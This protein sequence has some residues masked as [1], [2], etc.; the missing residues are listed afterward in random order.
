MKRILVVF[1]LISM[2]FLLVAGVNFFMNNRVQDTTRVVVGSLLIIDVILYGGL[3][4]LLNS[5]HIL[6]RIVWVGV[7][8]SNILLT[9][10]DNIGLADI[11][12]LVANALILLIYVGSNIGEETKKHPFV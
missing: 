9:I 7:I 3:I 2:V 4:F 8:A 11:L 10:V 12:F 1:L 5:R 6:V